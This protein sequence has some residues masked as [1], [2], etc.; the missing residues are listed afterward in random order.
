MK[1]NLV[2]AVLVSGS[3]SNLQAI[4][5]AAERGEIPGRVGL[6]LSN[7]ADAYGLTRA[8]N[9]G[10]PTAVVDHKAYG[11]R[12]EFDAKMVEAIRASG[13]RLVC[14]AGF[15]RVVTPVF[16]RA[17]PHRILNIHPAL[18]PSFPGTHGPGQA[19]RYGVRFSG[20]T[21][22]FL[23]EGVDTG[24]IIVQAV[25]PV[26]EDDTEETLAARILKEEHRIYPVAIRLFLEGRL[27]VSG[28]RV[29]TRD[30]TRIPDFSRRNPD[31]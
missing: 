11:S 15:M 18:L 5:D 30:T 20:C 17:F 19:L 8:R 31:A 22:H 6:V 28:R 13:A 2:I 26:H 21:V 4:I 25:V 12:E 3:G 10:I 16:L 14:L 27:T 29:M 1:E 7:K 23:D 24:P 9:H